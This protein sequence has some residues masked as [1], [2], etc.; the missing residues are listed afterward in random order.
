[1]LC[2]VVNSLENRMKFRIVFNF[3]KNILNS[4]KMKVYNPE[5]FN[6]AP[7]F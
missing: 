2:G 6:G 1:M 7:V 5:G 3:P 4:S